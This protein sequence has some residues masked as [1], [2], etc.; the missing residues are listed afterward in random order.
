M[1]DE[2]KMEELIEKINIYY[3]TKM[4]MFFRDVFM[5][6]FA[7]K[8]EEKYI[9]NMQRKLWPG[10]IEFD[11]LVSRNRKIRDRICVIINKGIYNEKYK[12]FFSENEL[13]LYII[14]LHEIK[15]NYH[16]AIMSYRN[17]YFRFILTLGKIKK[18]INLYSECKLI[19]DLFQKYYEILSNS[20]IKFELF[21]SEMNDWC[22]I[23][24][25][26][27]C[28]NEEINIEDM[29]CYFHKKINKI[30]PFI[31]TKYIELVH[32]KIYPVYK[33]LQ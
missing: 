32:S 14:F 5:F 10:E 33:S 16:I 28:F 20:K 11:S 18:F 27:Y 21:F 22:S 31:K 1:A 24:F 30:T 23:E 19:Y 3:D 2:V 7:S 26:Q 12:L 25:N 9:D 29:T 4:D 13:I 15:Q 17:C 6:D 8:D